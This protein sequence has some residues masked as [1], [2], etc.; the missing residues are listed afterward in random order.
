VALGCGL[1]VAYTNGEIEA[2]VAPLF[3]EDAGNITHVTVI[4]RTG[5]PRQTL[6]LDT[7]GPEGTPKALHDTRVVYNVLAAAMDIL[8]P[9]T[10]NGE[11]R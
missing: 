8:R 11:S 7:H 5:T 2:L 3:S 10:G 1:T 4:C 9:L 6:Y